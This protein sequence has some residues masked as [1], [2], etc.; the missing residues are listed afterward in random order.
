MSDLERKSPNGAEQKVPIRAED[1]GGDI[2]Q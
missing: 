1:A 2:E